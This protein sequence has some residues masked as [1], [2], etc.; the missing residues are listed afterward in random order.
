MS[1]ARPE[2]R[3]AIACP[4]TGLV[5][6]GFE[7]FFGDLFRVLEPDMD[8]TLFKGGGTASERERVLRFVHR[9]SPIPRLVP[10]HRLFGR[11]PMHAECLTFALAWLP[12]IVGG[13]FDVL[14]V[15]DPPLARFMFG[16][17]RVLGL[18]F[19]LLFTEGTSMPP[20]DYPPADHMHHTS[21]Q[22]HDAALRYGYPAEYLTAMPC[23][24]DSTRFTTKS[25]R[26]ELRAQYGVRP[27]TFVI[28]CVA[29]LNRGHKRVDHVVEE[30]AR[31]QGDVLL[32]LDG[33]LDH[34]E[35][36]LIDLAKRRLGDRCRVTCV[37]SD[38]VGDLYGLADI[39]VLASVR[40]AF[41]LSPLEASAAGL[42]VLTHDS[43]H[44]H[45]LFP[46]PEDHVDMT[47]VG[48]LSDRLGHL[49]RCPEELASL[50]RGAET[51]QRFDWSSVAPGYAELYRRVAA[52]P[53]SSHNPAPDARQKREQRVA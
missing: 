22:A 34:G 35:P 48:A 25:S 49:M 5:Q 4:G 14:H 9:N 15:I 12:H 3:V 33:S 29:A 19:R 45:W 24:I 50:G 6:R 23:G 11:T 26:A 43:P 1:T 41:G 10:I 47:R 18:S 20:S 30:V 51:R 32:W 38:R 16:V 2:P 37:A 52:L 7:R 46:H 8:V 39:K 42:P 27:E 44:F 31:L 36:A 53:I 13:G 28:L 21:L 40:E 17:R